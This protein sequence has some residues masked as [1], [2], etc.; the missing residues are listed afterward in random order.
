[1]L[2]CLSMITVG[3]VGAGFVGKA[4]ALYSCNRVKVLMFDTDAHRCVPPGTTMQELV[5]KCELVFVC[6][7]TPSEHDGKCHTDIV[8]AVVGQ[9]KQLRGTS[10]TPHIVVKSTVPPTTCAQLGVNHMPEFLTE[11]AWALDFRQQKIWI[12]GEHDSTDATFRHAMQ[13]LLNAAHYEGAIQ[14]CKM[15]VVCT[16]VSETVKY[17]RNTFLATKVSFFNEIEEYCRL[18]FIPFQIVRELVVQDDRVGESHTHV[19]GPDGKRGFGGTCL[20]KDIASLVFE[21]EG[22]GMEPEILAS[23]MNRN[24]TKDRP[25]QDWLQ[26]KGRAAL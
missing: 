26:D 23:V 21:M 13:E 12:V 19:P 24:V 18:K 1:M 20:P 7:P 25:E 3:V 22:A 9:L 5:N 14:S 16:E 17:V 4:T 11:R 10:S 6:V 2:A 8:A 15:T